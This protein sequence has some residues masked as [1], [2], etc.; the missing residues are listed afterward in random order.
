MWHPQILYSHRNNCLF[1]CIGGY[2]E[3][4]AWTTPNGTSGQTNLAYW[5]GDNN[6]R[7]QGCVT[8][9]DNISAPAVGDSTKNVSHGMVGFSIPEVIILTQ[10][11]L[12]S[13]SSNNVGLLKRA[14]NY[15][16]LE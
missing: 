15:D 4:A 12:A 11:Q 9:G 3:T 8:G 1:I 2:G 6:D 16:M 13:T 10:F 5:R 14:I 7:I